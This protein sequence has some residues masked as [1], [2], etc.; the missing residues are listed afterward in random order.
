[1][2]QEETQV[3]MRLYIEG[4]LYEE[5]TFTLLDMDILPDFYHSARAIYEAI[6]QFAEGWSDS[7]YDSWFEYDSGEQLNEQ[8]IITFVVTP[9]K[10]RRSLA[11]KRVLLE[12]LGETTQLLE[13]EEYFMNYIKK[14]YNE[15][16][17]QIVRFEW[18]IQ[19]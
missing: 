9:L 15:W 18:R 6:E 19:K 16:L 3:L 7:F 2:Y 17:D 1:M 13:N 4:E 5:D 12:Q 10:E 11:K 14:R 8:S